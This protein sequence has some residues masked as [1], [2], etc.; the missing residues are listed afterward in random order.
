MIPTQYSK[1]TKAPFHFDGHGINDANGQRVTKVREDLRMVDREEFDVLSNLFAA[2]PEMQDALQD[3]LHLLA[4]YKH[5]TVRQQVV[6]DKVRSA[7]QASNKD[8]L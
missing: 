2:A 4:M 6:Y 8:Y 3:V 7:L 5:K 1:H